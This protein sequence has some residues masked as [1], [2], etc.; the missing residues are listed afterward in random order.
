MKNKTSHIWH[1]QLSK[2]YIGRLERTTQ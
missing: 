2:Q 1:R